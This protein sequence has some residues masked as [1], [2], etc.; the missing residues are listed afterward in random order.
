MFSASA[1]SNHL[2]TSNTISS[3]QMIFTEWN[4]NDPG[5]IKKLGNYRYR[6][7]GLDIKYSN[8]NNYVSY[9]ENDFENYYTGA[10]DSDIVVDGG[11]N[12]DDEPII[13]ATKKQKMNMLY[14][15]EDCLKPNRP[16]S[17]INKLM[18]L[19]SSSVTNQ[20]FDNIDN[21]YIGGSGNISRRPRYYISSKFDQFKYWTS[22]RNEST[23]NINN[24]YGT[25]IFNSNEIYYIYDACPF[26]VYQEKVPT[27][28]IVIKMQTGVGDE[29]LGPFRVNNNI[30]FQD[31]LY[32]QSN[33]KT[34]KRWKIQILKGTTWT[35]I[36]SFDENSTRK[37]G[38][39]IIKSDG[40]VEIEYGLDIPDIFKDSY[41]F[42]GNIYSENE[43]PNQSPF[44]YAYLL[45]SSNEDK[46]I[47]VISN[48]DGSYVT[49]P[50]NSFTY[51]WT[52]SEEDMTTSKKVL[53]NFVDPDFY[54]ENSKTY[55]REFEFIDGM[56]IMVDTMNKSNCT[57]DLI[58]MSPRLFA[59]ISDKVISYSIVKTLS[60]LGSTSIP[61][62]N[63]F[64]STGQIQL[65]DED[66][67]FNTNNVFN[68]NTNTGSII[69]EYIDMQAK[70]IFYD[71]I[72]NVNNYDY[73]IPIKTL[74]SQG[75][76]QVN[77]AAATIDI[78]L[79]DM[80]FFFEYEKAPTMMLTNI[81]LSYAITIMLDNIGFNNYVFKKLSNEKELIIPYFFIGPDQN[82]AEILQQLAVSSQTAMFF[83]EYNNF[84]VMSKKYL[85]ASE[86]ERSH[87]WTLYGQTA[88]NGNLPN[89]VNISSQQ[90]RVYNGGQLNYTTRYIQKSM[91]S[92][93]Q[94]PYIDEYKTYINK[95][96]LL[97]EIEGQEKAQTINE[98]SNKSGGS[99][100]FAAPLKSNLSASVPYVDSNGIIKNNI[101]DFGENLYWIGK[102]NGYF[103]GNSEIIRF[104]AVEYFVMGIGN[105]W[106]SN[107]HE[108]QDYF[109]KLK[110]NSKMYPTGNVRIYSEPQYNDD[111]TLK[112]GTVKR[113]GRGQFGTNVIEHVA[114]LVGDS[115]WT[116][117]SYTTGCMQEARQYLFNLK[118]KIEYPNNLVPG[119]AGKKRNTS[120]GFIDA[121][122]YAKKS[123]RSGIIKNFMANKNVS[124]NDLNYSKTA[125]AGTVQSSALI[126]NGPKLPTGV[127]SANFVTYT[128]KNLDRPYKHFGTR[129][130]VIGKIES[131]SS[132]T[133]SPNGSF[134]ILGENVITNMDSG[135]DISVVGG[136]GGIGFNINT[137]SNNG[138][139][140]EIV[141]LSADSIDSYTI[142]DN[143]SSYKIAK[144]PEGV[145]TEV[146]NDIVTVTTE[147][148]HNFNIGDTVSI[149]GLID[150][151]KTINTNTT[152]N[153]QFTVTEIS[154]D[155]KSFKYQITV[156]NILTM[157]VVSASGN[158][159]NASYA[160]LEDNFRIGQ[161]VNIF[162]SNGNPLN[163]SNGFIKSI[164]TKTD[165]ASIISV[166]PNIVAGQVEY[167]T[168]STHS[169]SQGQWIK[170]SGTQS[171]SAGSGGID[172]Y[173]W[174][175]VQISSVSASNKFRILSNQTDSLIIQTGSVSGEKYYLNIDNT[176]NTL[177]TTVGI[178]TY[179]PLNTL[180]ING[181]TA[182]KNNDEAGVISN[183]LFYKITSGQNASDIIR[184]SRVSNVTTLTT[185]NPHNF[186]VG[187]EITVSDVESTFNGIFTITSINPNTIS[188]NNT[189]ADISTTDQAIIGKAVG[190]EKIAVPEILW[191]GFSEII[192]DDGKFTG[193]SRF[194]IKDK[195][196]V[197]DLNVE[198]VNIGASRKFYLYLN[199]R[200]IA[201][202]TDDNALNEY[203]NMAVFVRGS[204][205]CMFENIYAISDNFAEGNSS[206]LQSPMSKATFSTQEQ[207]N[208]QSSNNYS[209][210]ELI[211]RTFLSGIRTEAYP[212]YD[213]YYEEFGTIMR[214]VSYFNIRYDR[215]YPALYAKIAETAN[216]NKM[217]GVS[218]F[219]AGSYGA[220]FLIFNCMD[221]NIN[222][223]DTSGNYLRILGIA[224]TQNTTYTLT[225][226]DYF[227]KMSNF[228]DPPIYNNSYTVSDYKKFYDEIKNSRLKYGLNEFSLD[229]PYLQ[230]TEAAE[231]MMDWIIKKTLF[232]RKTVGVN[233]FA[234]QHLQLG[235]IITIDYKNNEGVYVIGDPSKRYVIYNIEY[236][237]QGNGSNMTIYLAEI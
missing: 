6:P 59:N 74:Y 109:S 112:S 196:T 143:V 191:R 137:D 64:A 226:D 79:R 195:P 179:V 163:V 220:E 235:D 218:G 48:G 51:S 200:Q 29:D 119:I 194:A 202:A 22:Y 40:Y 134:S 19:G 129:M 25:S 17:G 102:Y 18:F 56:R 234:T 11:Y 180:C 62:G 132:K 138:Y 212:R 158:G 135:K 43:L 20:V 24:E 70:F 98:L 14:S 206:S 214:E 148:Q 3:K 170:I 114:G 86:S 50:S 76:P 123:T 89:I 44:G 103:Y 228:S 173:N 120:A 205:R 151:N 8:P 92:I 136:S 77:D 2:K 225:V 187:D 35:T 233:T 65:F 69:S 185:A 172:K 127:D 63:L 32:G 153:G 5:N 162:I 198:Y 221:K 186:L 34:P 10:T 125:L 55:F 133:Q 222:L 21:H 53:N 58:E 47:L 223:D 146:I 139:F 160:I 166:T 176:S 80:F 231:D 142:N 145:V 67:S 141:A 208:T 168:S 215:A 45:K 189:G 12:N 75:F 49:Y 46:G 203:Q 97:W 33:S 165:N 192:V 100:L 93:K 182:T 209:I 236:Q 81:S 90:K 31:P 99:S 207:N 156:P 108:Y 178:I 175:K 83:D 232:P 26:V 96:V 230:T 36:I 82:V 7:G 94:A 217:F 229:S 37:D 115:Y 118:T 216:R 204:S 39:S 52:I 201:Q 121:D 149:S 190:N 66:F 84:V 110:F 152:V 116:T 106:I 107:N 16:R 91:G 42:V 27:N 144:Y 159:T 113:H 140:Y 73:F 199:G 150:K 219:Y 54:I 177:S 224:F 210:N 78:N 155:R 171:S 60:D 95:P 111:G 9:N 68:K 122:I 181:G 124:E 237:K 126:Y 167:T 169:F 4:L 30:N 41:V 164:Q 23:D 57:F 197:Y 161:I 188:Y 72:K 71:V 38:S 157:S 88:S 28:K 154:Q 183:V 117:N 213:M 131:N 105:V 184:R 61:V 128:Y 13:F 211:Q 87:D 193:Q 104:D 1:L 174:Q 85:M 130:R 227:K 15:L 147:T 101:V